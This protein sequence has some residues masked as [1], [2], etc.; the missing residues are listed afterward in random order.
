[1][2][3]RARNPFD[4]RDARDEEV[5]NDE[6]DAPAAGQTAEIA[7]RLAE[8]YGRARSES[9][10]DAATHLK[11]GMAAL[12]QGR[13]L[14]SLAVDAL[15]RYTELRPGDPNGH[16]RLG[17]ARAAAGDYEGAA[18]SYLKALELDQDDP[19]ILLALHFAH[20]AR[21]RFREARYC[22][23]RA[24][25]LK[26]VTEQEDLDARLFSCWEG[27]DLLLAGDDDEAESLLREAVSVEGAVGEA[28][29]YALALLAVRRGD[30]DETETHSRALESRESALSPSLRV[31]I[32]RGRFEPAE[33]VRALTANPGR[34]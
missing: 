25:K 28:A 21:L 24:R 6:R 29:H 19:D 16:Y 18:N 22:V 11:F 7:E 4:L 23:A 14:E 17:L 32:S 5:A 12:E 30:R 10:D 9:P 34:A 27:I 13:G 20:F 2:S 31:V 8:G 33:A 15:G 3:G 1:M 26:S